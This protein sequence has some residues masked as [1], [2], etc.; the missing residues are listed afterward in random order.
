[1]V[2]GKVGTEIRP[3]F[4][5]PACILLLGGALLGFRL[6]STVEVVIDDAGSQYEVESRATSVGDL[7]EEQE[8][9]VRFHDKI[10]P[11]VYAPLKNGMK[12]TIERT[13]PIILSVRGAAATYYTSAP[14]VKKFLEEMNI[15]DGGFFVVPPPENLL[16]PGAEITLIPRRVVSEFEQ[17]KIPYNTFK[18]EDRELPKGKY[19]VVQQGHEG[20]LELEYKVVYAGDKEFSR[21]LIQE[22]ILKDPQD[23]KVRIGTA[24]RVAPKSPAAVA[25]RGERI[26]DYSREGLASWYGTKFH[27]RRTSS[28]EIF[29]Q[30]GLT[31]AHRQ[32]PFGTQ[33][34]V[35]FLRTG[36]SV[37]VTINDRGPQSSERI[38]DLSM[39]AADRIGLKPY[40]VGRVRIEAI[41]PGKK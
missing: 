3:C 6:L 13:F 38:I 2:T 17:K 29:D 5:L 19:T 34:K 11:G 35:T 24:P 31:G 22:K 20:I 1:M 26:Y 16:L 10:Y 14:T 36:K 4:Y 15:P 8:I 41:E 39:A 37:Y 7:L 23:A 25:S 18:E 33:V 9:E 40:G 27:G 12:I 28:G 21:E 32:L 30:N